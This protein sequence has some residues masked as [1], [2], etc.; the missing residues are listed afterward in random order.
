MADDPSLAQLLGATDEETA[1]AEDFTRMV[2]AMSDVIG[3]L[4]DGNWRSLHEKMGRLRTALDAADRKI[5]ET[6]TEVSGRS[7]AYRDP[8]VDTKRTVQLITAYAQNDGGRLGPTLLPI[9]AL[10]NPQAVAQIRAKQEAIRRFREEL[11]GDD[12]GRR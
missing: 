5:S 10:D 1:L 11:L 2:R 9:D 6:P 4:E 7:P 8:V 12:D 3:Y